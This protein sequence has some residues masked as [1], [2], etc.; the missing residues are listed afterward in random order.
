MQFPYPKAYLYNFTSLTL[1]L[2]S[3]EPIKPII[4]I[5]E[6][7]KEI[8][9]GDGSPVTMDIGDNVTAASNTSI[10]IRCPVSGTP[11]PVVI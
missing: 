3:T 8:P 5:P 9:V 4:E 10:T 11:T 1:F 2:S 7:R 6:T